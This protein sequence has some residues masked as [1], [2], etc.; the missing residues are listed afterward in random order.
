MQRNDLLSWDNDVEYSHFNN[1]G[2]SWQAG[3]FS[4]LRH[5]Y[6]KS[7]ELV[8][9]TIIRSA[10]SDEYSLYTG[11]YGN[12]KVP[13]N[14]WMEVEGGL[15]LAYYGHLGILFRLAPRLQVNVRQ[16]NIAMNL[17]YDRTYH[18]AHLISPLGFNMPADLGTRPAVKLPPSKPISSLCIFIINPA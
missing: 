7:E 16:G 17:S 5:Y 13:V 15:R 18:F 4:M 11:I 1:S 12:M 14:A 8:A 2:L 9:N 3:A 10:A 6:I